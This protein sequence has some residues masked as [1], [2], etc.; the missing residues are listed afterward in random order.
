MSNNVVKLAVVA[1]KAVGKMITQK[2]AQKAVQKTAQKAIQKT[3]QNAAQKTAQNAVQKTAQKSFNTP[4]GKPPIHHVECTS[5]KEAYEAARQA[6]HKNE[7]IHHSTG[8]NSG[9]YH[10]TNSNGEK[11]HGPHYDYGGKDKNK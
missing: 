2:T 10:S 11:V 1:A 7:P 8:N 3:A 6:G 5:K 9:H 4:S